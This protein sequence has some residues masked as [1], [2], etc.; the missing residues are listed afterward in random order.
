MTKDMVGIYPLGFTYVLHHIVCI[1]LVTSFIFFDL[2]PAFMLAGGTF[3]EIGSAAINSYEMGYAY[4]SNTIRLIIGLI[5]TI[6]NFAVIYVLYPYNVVVNGP[7]RYIMTVVVSALLVERERQCLLSIACIEQPI[8]IKGN[9]SGKGTNV[10][11]EKGPPTYNV[12]MSF[13][14]FFTLA[15]AATLIYFGNLA[16]NI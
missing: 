4:G 13:T 5:M 10:K 7:L 2:P 6:S 12:P 1:F 3:A 8:N 16:K 14:I 15:S 9:K 11:Y